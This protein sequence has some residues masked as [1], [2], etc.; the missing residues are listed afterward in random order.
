MILNKLKTSFFA[1]VFIAF[2]PICGNAI[3]LEMKDSLLVNKLPQIIVKDKIFHNYVDS[4]IFSD[5]T[6][7]SDHSIG[8][9][10]LLI[11]EEDS[12]DMYNIEI[13]L[14]PHSIALYSS[15][16]QG[17]FGIK[18]IPCILWG[19]MPSGL[20]VLTGRK[21]IFY[22]M[23][24]FNKIDEDY[25]PYASIVEYPVWYFSYNNGNFVYKGFDCL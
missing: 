24:K 11:L 8:H 20:F 10:F 22:Y 6:C 1:F 2:A 3:T 23:K 9:I 15:D 13:S 12:P 7:F 4:L 25:I 17:Y 19:D 5:L 16:I 21:K 18:N 14:V